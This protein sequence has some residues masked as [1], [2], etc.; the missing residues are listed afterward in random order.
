MLRFSTPPLSGKGL[1]WSGFPTFAR[2]FF[3]GKKGWQDNI[4]V[5]L[6]SFQHLMFAC[7]GNKEIPKQP[8]IQAHSSSLRCGGSLCKVRNDNRGAAFTLAEVL[9]T[10]VIIGVVAALTIPNIMQKY[11]EQTTVKKVQKFHSNLANAYSLAIKDHGPASEWGFSGTYN[12]ES[13]EKIYKILFK[14]YFKIAKNCGG[15]NT[16][17][18]FANTAYKGLNSK[19][20]NNYSNKTGFYKFTLD[21]GSTV[22]NYTSGNN[23]WIVYDT[24][25]IKGPNQFGRDTFHFL[26]YNDK[27][28]PYG[29][30]LL[31]KN[32]NTINTSFQTY[33]SPNGDPDSTNSGISCA[34]WV[35]YKGNM[36]YLHCD[37]L[38]WDGKDKC[39]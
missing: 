37:D 3:E 1:T 10:L 12:A 25:G 27:F 13:A 19:A 22:F 30:P 8:C 16:G 26:I 11:T 24:N 20:I 28:I 33:C 21:D 2:S 9:I 32:I 38:S 5:M 17:N 29:S 35:V 23:I 7:T 14:S 4:T 34:A 36:D 39:K 18:C 6:N 15:D 31:A